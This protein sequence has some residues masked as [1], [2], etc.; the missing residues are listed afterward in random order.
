ATFQAARRLQEEKPEI[1][2]LIYQRVVEEQS[3]EE[4]Q[5]HYAEENEG[6]EISEEALRQRFSRARKYLRSIFKQLIT[7]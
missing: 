2:W 1:Y 7:T 5:A 4:I 3:W 6:E